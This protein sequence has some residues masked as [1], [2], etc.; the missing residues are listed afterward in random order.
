M[1]KVFVTSNRMR[2]DPVTRELKPIVDLRPA[3]QFGSLVAVFDHTMDPD[4]PEDVRIAADRLKEFNEETDFVL[5]NGSPLATF[6]TG[7]LLGGK[8]HRAIQ[9]LVW[10]KIYLRYNLHLVEL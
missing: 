4:S 3:E 2:K 1:S 10:D 9:A 7:L 8:Q 6:A 5:P